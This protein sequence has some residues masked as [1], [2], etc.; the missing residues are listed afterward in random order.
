MTTCSE[1]SREELADVIADAGLHHTKA[2]RIK[3]L[4][5]QLTQRHGSCELE[6]L[7]G[8]TSAQISGVSTQLL[9]RTRAA[10]RHTD[11]SAHGPEYLCQFP[12]VGSKT[13]ACV[14]LC[15]N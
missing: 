9:V 15:D 12:G 10:C 7:K 14:G 4:L 2:A 5:Q 11:S 13:V 6:F 3:D 1:V 8:W